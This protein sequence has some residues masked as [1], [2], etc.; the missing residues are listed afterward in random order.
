MRLPVRSIR[1]SLRLLVFRRRLLESPFSSVDEPSEY[2]VLLVEA[3]G[4]SCPLARRRI[5]RVPD[6]LLP[7]SPHFSWKTVSDVQFDLLG[8]E[9][10]ISPDPAQCHVITLEFLGIEVLS[11]DFAREVLGNLSVTARVFEE[12]TLPDLFSKDPPR[13]YESGQQR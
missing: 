11:K 1:P 10:E 3:E 5:H 13:D 6:C 4:L 7:V 9:V 8:T 2:L 12:D